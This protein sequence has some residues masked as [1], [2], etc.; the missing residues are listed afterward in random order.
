MRVLVTGAYG[1][2]GAHI[3]A[4]LTAGGHEVVCAVRGARVDTRFPGL[5]A[6]ACDMARDL[7]CE[8][9]LPRLDGIDTV[10]NCA[11]I[12]RERGADTYAAVHEQAPLA[13]FQAC[14]RRGV[15]RAIQI[16]AL[17]DPADGDFVASKHRG[18]AAL[19]ALKLDWL[20]LRPSLVYSARGSY[21][22]SSLLRALAALPGALPLPAGGTQR[23]QPIAAEDVG[24]AV[25]AA[26]ARPDVAHRIIELVGPEAMPLRDYLLAWRRWLGFGRV[27]ILSVPLPLARGVAA[28]GEWLGHGPLGRT[29]LRM[30]ERGNVGAAD[31]V[32]RLR[33]TLGLSPRSLQRALNEAPSQVQD[34]WHARLYCWLPLLRVLLALLWLGSGVVGWTTSAHEMQA[35]AAGSPLGG[36]AALWLT[37][38]TASVDL[39]LGALCLLR[40]RPR[41]VLGAMLAMLL[42]YTLGVGLLWPA[43]WLAPFGG[44]LKN[45]PLIAALAIL[46]ATD[47]RR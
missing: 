22:G 19:A 6:I 38:L 41:P 12:L 24:V 32:T 13:L 45:L 28:L 26:L 37:R 35:L 40:W 30:L 14:V 20:V 21:G 15:R 17:G 2:I 42:G 44:L 39:S 5:R 3:V 31:A 11:G 27:R 43:Q 4:A 25:V 23:V 1:F 18:D 46:L 33:D 34:R 36:E 16:S 9:W 47:E 7:R 29:M 8:D 10:V